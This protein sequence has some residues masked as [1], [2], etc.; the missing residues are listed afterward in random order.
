[1]LLNLMLSKQ[2][3]IL[4]INN[5]RDNRVVNYSNIELDFRPQ[6]VLINRLYG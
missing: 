1:M 5:I 3:V 6:V 2:Y 4:I